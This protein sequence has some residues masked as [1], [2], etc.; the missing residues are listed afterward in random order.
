MSVSLKKNIISGILWNALGQFGRQGI[1]FFVAIILARILLPAEF[2]LIGMLLVF[3]GIADVFINS[4]LGT[5]L[6]QKKDANTVDYSTVF[7]FNVAVSLFFYILLYVSAPAISTFYNEPELLHLTRLMALVFVINAFGT[8]QSTI[9]TIQLNFKKYNLIS[10]VGVLI[11]AIIALFMAY[12]NYGVYSLAGQAI[13]YAVVTNILYWFTSKWKPELIFS[14]SSFRSLFRFASKILLSSLLDKIFTTIDSLVV[15]KVFNAAQLGYY[16]RAKAT[17]DLPIVNTT[18]IISS[19]FFPVFSKLDND[20]EL[21]RYHLRFFSLIAYLV[22]PLMAGLF[23]V[24]RPFTV[25]LFTEKWIESVPMLQIFCLFGP[26]YPLSVILVQTILVKGKANKFLELDIYKKTVL[27]IA[28]GIGA[29]F[30]VIPFLV[31][32]CLSNFAG[33]YLNLLFTSKVIG[34]TLGQYVR[35]LAPSFAVT[36]LMAVVVYLTGFVDFYSDKL[37]LIVQS[38]TGILVYVV[39]SRIFKLSEYNYLV[40]SLRK[41]LKI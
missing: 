11:S 38:A 3:S 25:T 8:V 28:M 41:R 23:V 37:L 16:T 10:L 15:G 29:Y 34:I 27:L 39:L 18:G 30:G 22:L 12:K 14:M 21:R 26:V 24:A 35:C 4:G 19:V 13:S 2:G 32:L 36:V 9:L 20:D 6:I 17:R 5:A 33:F 40:Q 7:Y 1:S 31:A